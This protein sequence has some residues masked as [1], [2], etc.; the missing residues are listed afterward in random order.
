M[1]ITSEADVERMPVGHGGEEEQVVV[2]GVDGSES[3]SAALAWGAEEARLRGATLRVVQAW[4]LPAVGYGGPG[5]LPA[6][7]FEGMAGEISA[8]LHSQVTETLGTDPAVRL[9]EHVVEGSAA[10]VILDASKGA[11]MVVVGSHGRGGFSGLLLGSVSAQVAHHAR[12]PV[13]IVRS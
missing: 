5:Y 8:A 3:S 13:V 6:W 11:E 7:T 4:H 10:E 9:E 2:V 1:A 12:C